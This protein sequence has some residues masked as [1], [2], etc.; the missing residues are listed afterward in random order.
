MSGSWDTTIG[1]MAERVNEDVVND[2]GWFE[3][4]DENDVQRV[5]DTKY[6]Y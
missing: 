6:D 2:A 1:A 5:S 3:G 4:I